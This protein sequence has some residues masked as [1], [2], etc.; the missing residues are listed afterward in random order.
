VQETE[1]YVYI[2]SNPSHTVFYTGVTS[3]L[4]RRI[5]EHKSKL[6]DGFTK[7][8]NVTQL[9]YFE[10]YKSPYQAI[11]REKQIKHWKQEWKLHTIKK[12][13]P[14]FNDLYNI[15]FS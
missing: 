3:D 10:A 5:Y 13:N 15:L 14:N 11:T 4:S 2:M 8:Y 6:I 1:Y 12:S 9:L 7:K